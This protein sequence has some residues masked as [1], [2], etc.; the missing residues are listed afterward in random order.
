MT[1][2]AC[3]LLSILSDRLERPQQQSVERF[4]GDRKTFSSQDPW[5][6]FPS[7]PALTT[8]SSQILTARFTIRD[9]NQS[10]ASAILHVLHILSLLCIIRYS[11]DRYNRGI[12]TVPIPLVIYRRPSSVVHIPSAIPWPVTSPQLLFEA[13]VIRRIRQADR[14]VSRY[15]MD[16]QL[17]SSDFPELEFGL[18]G[19]HRAD[20]KPP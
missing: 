1:A 9:L 3:A 8:C 20:E 19:P 5:P 17:L 7:W 18:R 14:V 11:L 16:L 4:F 15:L 13:L 10:S 6:Q 12:N 2:H